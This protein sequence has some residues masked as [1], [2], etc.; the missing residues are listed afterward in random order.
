M[1]PV[2]AFIRHTAMGI[3]FR[4]QLRNSISYL[5]IPIQ[6]DVRISR[7]HTLKG[8]KVTYPRIFVEELSKATRNL[9]S[10]NSAS[11]K[12]SGMV[13]F[14]AD[15]LNCDLNISSICFLHT[16]NVKEKNE[17]VRVRNICNTPPL[18]IQPINTS[19]ILQH[20]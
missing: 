5:T 11:I 7:N 15:G 20:E 10:G 13:T 8:V 12:R 6:I 16:A 2:M 4:Q 1:L 18:L 17:A 14:G 3:G 19:T 9:C